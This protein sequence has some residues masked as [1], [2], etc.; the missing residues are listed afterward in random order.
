[1]KK[2][3]YLDVIRFDHVCDWLVQLAGIDQTYYYG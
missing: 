1:M 3:L 2:N